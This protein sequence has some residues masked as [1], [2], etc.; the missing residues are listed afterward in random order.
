VAGDRSGC[1]RSPMRRPGSGC[2]EAEFVQDVFD[3]VLRGSFGNEQ[4]VGYLAIGESSGE[5]VDDLALAPGQLA[6]RDT[7]ARGVAQRLRERVG[8]GAQRG[9]CQAP[10][11]GGARPAAS[12]RV[13][14]TLFRSPRR[15]ST[16]ASSNRAWASNGGRPAPLVGVDR[17][18]QVVGGAVRLPRVADSIPRDSCTDPV[19][20]RLASFWTRRSS[21]PGQQPSIGNGG[22]LGVV[23][24]GGQPGAFLDAWQRARAGHMQG[25]PARQPLVVRRRP[26]PLT[27]AGVVGGQVEV[28]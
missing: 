2:G 7:A 9:P 14:R 5:V 18:P 24:Q 3:V 28:P 12:R 6:G 16:R 22:A 20:R 10:R 17:G 15:L 19:E 11:R 25:V 8:T 26:V 21:R 23:E 27:P 1:W 4:H 13:P